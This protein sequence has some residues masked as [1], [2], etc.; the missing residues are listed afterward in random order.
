MTTPF[1]IFVL[2]VNVLWFGMGFAFFAV[3]PRRALRI[4]I[5][6]SALAETS[7]Q[8]LAASLPF[9]G[10]LNF[11]FAALSALFLAPRCFTGAAPLPWQVYAASGVAHASQWVCNLPHLRR[12]GRR[13]GAPWDV[14]RGTM[15][16]IF[17]MDAGCALLNVGA[18]LSRGARF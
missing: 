15:L 9:L 2:A 8:A 7:A 4:L 18:L 17:V 14:A 11:G 16:F 6:K 5:P 10:G 12:G 13:G 1:L 3:R